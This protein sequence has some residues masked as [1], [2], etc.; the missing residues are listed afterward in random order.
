MLFLTYWELNQDFDPSELAEIA[1]K[2]MSKKLYPVEGV[3]Q[4]GFY[5]ST[6]DYWGI[7]IEEAENEEQMVKGSMIW[8][9][10]KPGYIKVMRTTPAVDATKM[11]QMVM[12]L[13][14]Q[15]EG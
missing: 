15:M 1:Q 8:R 2:L 11:I 10:A 6:S 5:I 12:K 7:T 9:L 14:K 3:K 4:I 13:K